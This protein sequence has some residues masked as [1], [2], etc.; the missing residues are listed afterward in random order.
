M[1]L[2]STQFGLQIYGF[3]SAG[4]SLDQGVKLATYDVVDG[5][6]VI[7]QETFDQTSGLILELPVQIGSESGVSRTQ[8]FTRDVIRDLPL[9]NGQTYYFG[10]TAYN[11]NPDAT[12]SESGNYYIS[13]RRPTCFFRDHWRVYRSHF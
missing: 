13:W 12:I 10:V 7:S 1:L 3:P 4:A 8:T 6:R 11:Y 2:F 5:I 9:V